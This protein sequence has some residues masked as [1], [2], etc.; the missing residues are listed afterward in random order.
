M[1]SMVVPWSDAEEGEGDE[2]E[3]STGS[4]RERFRLCLTRNADDGV[5]CPGGFAHTVPEV[6][7]NVDPSHAQQS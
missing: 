6:A 7:E 2:G 3:S 4:D 1:A 5:L